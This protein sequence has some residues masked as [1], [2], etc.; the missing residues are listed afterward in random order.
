MSGFLGTVIFFALFYC[1]SNR[2]HFTGL[3]T[4]W[5]PIEQKKKFNKGKIISYIRLGAS[6]N[7]VVVSNSREHYGS[8]QTLCLARA[9]MLPTSTNRY[10]MISK[11]VFKLEVLRR[12]GFTQFPSA[13]S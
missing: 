9:V 10:K 1:W 2:N 11:S 4:I 8:R 13:V 6:F 7:T 12:R 3:Q 5:D